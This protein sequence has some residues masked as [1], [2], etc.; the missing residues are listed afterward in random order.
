[1]KPAFS[2]QGKHA[3]VRVNKSLSPNRKLAYRILAVDGEASGVL[4]G[5]ADGVWIVEPA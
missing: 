1:M 3:V 5:H 4:A 2:P